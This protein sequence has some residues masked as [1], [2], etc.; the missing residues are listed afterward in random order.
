MKTD[1]RTTDN[2]YFYFDKLYQLNLTNGVMPG[3]VYLYMPELARRF[4]WNAEQRLWFAFLNGLTQ[5]PITSLRMFERL[6]IVPPAGAE[7]KGFTE[8][9]NTNWDTLQFDTD[10]RYQKKDQG[11]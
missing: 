11:A 10:R 1:Y 8:W 5:N 4:D 2:R 7:L 3:L 9:F 6:P